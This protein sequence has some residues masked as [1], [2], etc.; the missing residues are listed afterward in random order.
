MVKPMKTTVKEVKEM[1]QRG[2]TRA[3]FSGTVTKMETKEVIVKNE[4]TPLNQMTVTDDT[5]SI[6]VNLWRAATTSPVKLGSQL[7]VEG[8]LHFNTYENQLVC[9]VNSREN[10]EIQESVRMEKAI[11]LLGISYDHTMQ[12]FLFFTEEE[13]E[14]QMSLDE[15]TK[16][17]PHPSED[18][19]S[20]TLPLDITCVVTEGYMTDVA[21]QD[22]KPSDIGQHT[23]PEPGTSGSKPSMPEP[24]TSGSKSTMPEPGTSV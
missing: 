23:M 2:C 10:V 16:I 24:G 7:S 21:I 12:K 22:I 9:H 1:Y 20:K 11:R 18:E 15:A 17:W 4:A 8:N 14:L 5:G 3:L 6:T 13:E 19:I